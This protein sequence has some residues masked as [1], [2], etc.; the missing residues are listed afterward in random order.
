MAR[1]VFHVPSLAVG[2]AE[3]VWMLMAGEMARR[4]HDTT[5][6]VWNAEGMTSAHMAP[7]LRLVDLA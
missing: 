1:L 5:L 7:Q 2:G 3:R 6:L 4:G